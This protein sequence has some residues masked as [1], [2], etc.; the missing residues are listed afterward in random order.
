MKEHF[1]E[2]DIL[3][4]FKLTLKMLPLTIPNVQ[5]REEDCNSLE[6]EKMS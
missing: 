4:K 1:V 5:L 2:N 3:K 6:C